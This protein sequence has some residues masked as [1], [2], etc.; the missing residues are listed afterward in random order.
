M[1][2]EILAPGMVYYKDAIID[3]EVTILHIESIQKSLSMGIKSIAKSWHEWNGA[4]PETEKFCKRH[5][6]VDPKETDENDPLYSDIKIVYNNIFNG[7][8]NAFKHYSNIL[9]PLAARNI[10]SSEGLLSI[11]KYSQS[12]YLPEHQDQ[13]VSSRVL[14]TVGYLND[15]YDGGEIYFPYVDVKIK[16]V[17]GSVL[18][19]PSNFVYVHEVMPMI[20]GVRYAVPQWYHSLSTPRMSTGEE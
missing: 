7:I 20:N 1:K 6:I 15:N 5:F 3:P 12:G 17:A 16:P 14:S 10:K 11:L 19:F 13:G 4:N 18:F 8:E 2:H 9:Y